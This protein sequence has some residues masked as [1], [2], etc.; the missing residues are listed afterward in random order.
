MRDGMVAAST[1]NLTRP[2]GSKTMKQIMVL[3]LAV[4]TVL[5]TSASNAAEIKCIC[6]EALRPV[7]TQVAPEFERASGHKLVITYELAP[8]VK[9]RIEQDESFDLTV[10]NPPQAADLAKQ[11][12]LAP[13]KI[14]N[15]ARAGLGIAVRAG[16]VKPDISSVEAFE[17]TMLDAHSVAFSEEG[18]SGAHFRALLERLGI[19]EQM[20]P[21]LRP[22][23]RGASFRM[24]ADGEAQMTFSLIPQVLANP[25]I[26][27]VGPIPGEL[28]TWVGLTAAIGRT[29]KQPEAA[30]ALIK[31]LK[32]P[33]VIALFEA[34]GWEAM[35]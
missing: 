4:A 23:A 19:T 10:L 26:D 32:T 12:K 18:T 33:E 13:D 24:V 25:G 6:A 28:Q 34:K 17:R 2:E 9:R 30:E 14:V 29:A 5:H 35:P 15:L 11:G 27:L 16:A 1:G 22:A 31:R 3:S 20:Q 21:K 7:L 8:V